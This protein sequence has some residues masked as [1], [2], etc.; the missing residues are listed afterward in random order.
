MWKDVC[1]CL[2]LEPDRE[3]IDSDDAATETRAAERVA[4]RVALQPN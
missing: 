4:G 2:S 1:F 3:G